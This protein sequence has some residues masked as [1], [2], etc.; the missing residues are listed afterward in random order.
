VFEAAQR[1]RTQSLHWPWKIKA[2]QINNVYLG[3]LGKMVI[4]PTKAARRQQ[5][6][7]VLRFGILIK[8]VVLRKNQWRSTWSLLAENQGWSGELSL[9]SARCH[10]I[11]RTFL[12]RTRSCVSHATC[13]NK[14]MA[15]MMGVTCLLKRDT[16]KLISRAIMLVGNRFHVI[17][18]AGETLKG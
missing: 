18:L 5:K 2:S 9:A 4:S 11:A 10:W 8:P 17:Q 1:R 3:G 15:E 7:R 6:I 16:R 13:G 12:R 14:I